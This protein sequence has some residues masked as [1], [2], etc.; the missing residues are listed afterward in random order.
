MTTPQE[1]ESGRAVASP[2]GRIPADTLPNRLMLARKLAG[3]SIR[4]AADLCGLGRGAWTKWETGSR[5]LDLLEITGVIA[6]K[7]D[8]DLEW[9]RFGGPLAPARGMSVRPASDT[10]RYSPSGLGNSLGY[11]AYPVST[12][13]PMSTMSRPADL[14]PKGREDRTR[15]M[16][17]SATG[18]RAALVR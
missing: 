4:E 17:P 14:R 15:P 10:V 16:S 13:R 11:A 12:D 18:R 6:E 7:L 8:V 3:L 5:P 2:R 9:L 1:Q